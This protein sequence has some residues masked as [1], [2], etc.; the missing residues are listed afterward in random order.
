MKKRKQ[1]RR[2]AKRIAAYEASRA[3]PVRNMGTTVGEGG[4]H[5]PGSQNHKKT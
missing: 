1:D 4:Y 2:L 3:K 5:R